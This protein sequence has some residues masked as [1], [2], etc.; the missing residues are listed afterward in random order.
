MF[1]INLISALNCLTGLGFFA[2]SII[3]LQCCLSHQG[4][5][6]GGVSREKVEEVLRE[7][8]ERRRK[9]NTETDKDFMTK[10]STMKYIRK[11]YARNTRE[12]NLNGY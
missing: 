11:I 2:G 1:R 8:R 12:S 5:D 10:R 9:R 7:R 4:E 6:I 3:Q